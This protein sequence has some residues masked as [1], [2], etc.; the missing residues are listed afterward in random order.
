M[1]LDV[2]ELAQRVS[3]QYIA[4]YLAVVRQHR[5]SG[6][7]GAAEVKFRVKEDA[8]LYGG[9]FC[10]D[11]VE[12]GPN[13]MVARAFQSERKLEFSPFS[14]RLGDTDIAVVSLSWDRVIIAFEGDTPDL[15]EWFDK[16]FDADE[17][18]FDAASEISG[19]IHSLHATKGQLE[20]DFGSAPAIALMDLIDVMRRAGIKRLTLNSD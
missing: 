19:R 16:W 5:A 15:R 9:I 1:S 4:Q 18:S 10:A 17:K 11:H 7:Q 6:I 20:V 3:E 8:A 14:Q 12:N 13:G 2:A